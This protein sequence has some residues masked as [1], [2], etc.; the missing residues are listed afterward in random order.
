MLTL[1]Q[2]LK[3]LICLSVIFLAFVACDKNEFS[4]YFEYDKI[5]L[6][7]GVKNVSLTPCFSIIYSSSTNEGASAIHT[8]YCDTVNPPQKKITTVGE[9]EF[10]RIKCPKEHQLEFNKKYYWYCDTKYGEGHFLTEISSFTTIDINYLQGKRWSAGHVTSTDLYDIENDSYQ[11]ST[12]LSNFLLHAE[13]RSFR[14]D[15]DSV[16]DVGRWDAFYVPDSIL[17]RKG[18]FEI[19]ND[20][21]TIMRYKY[22][23]YDFGDN[24]YKD[25][26]DNSIRLVLKA[27]RADSVIVF[28]NET[29]Y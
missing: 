18:K 15:G 19:N 20:T 11:N 7:D 17:P 28:N 9:S 13:P 1:N 4:S 29:Q 6:E 23:L 27:L 21:I 24:Y 12:P 26:S 14:I 25:N 3:K 2:F 5:Y 16:K 10:W 8:I 22:V